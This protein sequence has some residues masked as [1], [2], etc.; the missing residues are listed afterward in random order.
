MRVLYDTTTVPPLDRYEYYRAGAACELAPVEVDGRAPGRLSARMSVGRVGDFDLEE[1]TWAA[2][3]AIVT[4]RTERL[5]RVGSQES[6]RL[7]VAVAG[8]V[9]LEQVDS[10]VRI[11]PGDIG[12]YH[13]SRPW[14]ARHPAEQ[15]RIQVVMLTFPRAMLPVEE[16]ALGPLLGTLMP[17]R[18]PGRNLIAQLLVGRASSGEHA[19]CADALSDGVRG[20]IRD[21]L[22]LPGGMTPHTRRALHRARIRDV[23]HTRLHDPGLDPYGIARAAAISPRYLHEL[24][25]DTGSTPMRLVKR[26]R[27]QECRRRL[28]DPAFGSLAIREI[29]AA[30]GYRRPDQFARDFRQEFGVA[31]T[32][33]RDD[34]SG[35]R[36]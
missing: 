23:I 29:A 15:S 28:A 3:A 32:Q 27:L 12:L 14:R 25:K 24:Y 8:E 31:P 6:Y 21:W 22:G 5:I 11:R 7:V 20:L 30:C 13:L 18:L 17:R 33:V 1:L 4:R 16:R 9:Q 26:M 36:C 2:D 10:R 35:W 34:L 19:D